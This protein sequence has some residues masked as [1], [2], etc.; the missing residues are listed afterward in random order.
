MVCALATSVPKDRR[1]TKN[2]CQIRI[3]QLRRNSMPS[4]SPVTVTVNLISSSAWRV[5]A[6]VSRSIPF[7]RRRWRPS[8]CTSRLRQRRHPSSRHSQITPGWSSSSQRRRYHTLVSIW[9]RKLGSGAWARAIR[10]QSR[11]V[12]TPVSVAKP[13]AAT[14]WVIPTSPVGVPIRGSTAELIGKAG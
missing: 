12:P 1:T 10:T 13:S 4:V 6:L 8:R 14:C 5:D 3:A 11:D 2:K 9:L 7:R